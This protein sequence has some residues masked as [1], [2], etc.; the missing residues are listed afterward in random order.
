MVSCC[1][2]GFM[3]Y[4]TLCLEAT[5]RSM[6]S[7]TLGELLQLEISDQWPR[8]AMVVILRQ[9]QGSLASFPGCPV[10]SPFRLSPL[11]L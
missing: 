5:T 1:S 11:K 8:V 7:T 6:L 2:V 3:A 4:R 10:A 9:D